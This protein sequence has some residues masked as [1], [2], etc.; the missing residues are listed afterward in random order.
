[1]PQIGVP[2]KHSLAG[3]KKAALISQSGFVV[4]ALYQRLENQ[5][6]S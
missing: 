1:M 4:A 6:W 5:R 3:S 2:G